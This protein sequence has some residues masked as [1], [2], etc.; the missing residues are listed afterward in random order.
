M[1]PEYHTS[2]DDLTVVTPTGLE[3]S[4]TVLQECVRELEKA[5]RFL[6]ATLGEPQMG[7]RGLYPTLSNQAGNPVTKNPAAVSA[8]TLMNVLSYCDGDH[9]STDIETILGI[10][11]AEVDEATS[12]LLRTGL[13]RRA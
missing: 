9:D 12:V 4:L 13:L 1:F 2:L 6:A 11:A 5:P 10:S 8:R 7:R 3:E